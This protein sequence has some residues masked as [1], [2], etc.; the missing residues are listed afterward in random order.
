MTGADGKPSQ[1]PA[2]GDID[3]VT[4]SK[5]LSAQER[6]RGFATRREVLGDA[7]VDGSYA[8]DA[9]SR[10]KVELS[11]YVWS[12]I[13]SRP[14]LSRKARSI[15][16]LAML[17]ALNRPQELRLHVGAALNNGLTKEEICEVLLQTLVYCGVAAAQD[18]FRIAEEVF[19]ER[20]L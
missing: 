5:F 4:K 10:P 14:G 9:L 18:G 19:R 13:W 11:E 6:A 2:A 17:T 8:V 3:T 15:A 20:G 7:H 1:R 16:N 12:K